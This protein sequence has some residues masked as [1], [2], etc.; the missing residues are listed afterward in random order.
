MQTQY[1]PLSKDGLCHLLSDARGIYIPQNF[2]ETFNYKDWS[3]AE[4]DAAILLEGPDQEDYWD[5][6]HDVEQSAELTDK[7]GNKWLLHSDGD[8][9]AICEALLT[10][11]HRENFGYHD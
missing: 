2:I 6:W 4:G 1:E 10:K 5:T 7:H 11:E 3:V 9:W 8:L